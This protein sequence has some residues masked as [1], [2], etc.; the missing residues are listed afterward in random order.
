MAR[1]ETLMVD[2][3]DRRAESETLAHRSFHTSLAISHTLSAPFRIQP[4][5]PI[6]SRE[7]RDARRL[8]ARQLQGPTAAV[9]QEACDPTPDCSDERLSR[10]LPQIDLFGRLH[11]DAGLLITSQPE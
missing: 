10:T 4:D 11:R 6:P 7:S 2:Q 5:R 3:C 1:L 9:E 8:F